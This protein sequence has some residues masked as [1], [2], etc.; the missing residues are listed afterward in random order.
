MTS[1][2]VLP[3]SAVSTDP[4]VPTPLKLG[5]PT[6]LADVPKTKM[7]DVSSSPNTPTS[8]IP[9]IPLELSG[10]PQKQALIYG[11]ILDDTT[12]TKLN[13]SCSFEAVLEFIKSAK[14]LGL[15]QYYTLL[16]CF[17]YDD[18][19][20]LYFAIKYPWHDDTWTH[21]EQLRIPS[22]DILE[23]LSEKMQVKPRWFG[24]EDLTDGR[25]GGWNSVNPAPRVVYN[26]AKGIV[27]EDS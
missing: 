20:L 14:E 3:S 8:V 12:S 18:L 4:S 5:R 27:D 13:L 6:W 15:D 25:R 22:E 10:Q 9:P 1:T 23:K 24:Y 16:S 19:H 26:Y 17:A 2:I 11:Y 7:A 21:A